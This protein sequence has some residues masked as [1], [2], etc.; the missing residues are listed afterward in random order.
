M[1]NRQTWG[2]GLTA[3]LVLGAAYL[4]AGCSGPAANQAVQLVKPAYGSIKITVSTT[5]TVQPYNRLEVKP[6][7]GGRVDQMLVEEGD[8]VRRGQ[9]LAWLSSSE[10]A[11]LLDAARAEGDQSY[12]AWQDVYKP[13][14]VI[15]PINGTVIVR[16]VL[17]GQTV[18][19]TDNIYVLSDRLIVLAQVDETDIGK[20]KVGQAAVLTLDAYP[21]LRVPAR[22]D[23]IEYESKIV[24]NVTIYQVYLVP[25]RIPPQ[26]RSGMSA[27][28]DITVATKDNV[29]LVPREALQSQGNKFFVMVGQDP[30][31]KPVARPVKVGLQGDKQV[32]I[33]AGLTPND[34]VV[35]VPPDFSSL[36]GGETK[37]NPFMPSRP[38]GGG[39]AH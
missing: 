22:V 19:A 9:T 34:T 13:A 7:I 26:F 11:A 20:L 35:I 10:R 23:H 8:E 4:L 3:A 2:I 12:Q 24:N 25:S 30:Q 31:A 16:S 39:R 32:E 5:G 38:R 27:N 28:A 36:K 18:A 29:L 37:S 15:S 14:P 21:D 33:A 6:P 1:T 17:P